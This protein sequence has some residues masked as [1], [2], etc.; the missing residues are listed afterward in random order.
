[1][2]AKIFILCSF[3]LEYRKSVTKLEQSGCMMN[4]GKR[5]SVAKTPGDKGDVA[6]GAR[7]R[8]ALRDNLRRRKVPARA[9]TEAEEL[10]SVSEK[11]VEKAE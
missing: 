7:L 9:G 5:K 3:L 1:M 4:E 8:S 10:A 6:K 2:Q 11:M